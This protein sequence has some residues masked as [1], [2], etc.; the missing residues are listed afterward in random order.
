MMNFQMIVIGLL[1]CL[2]M[3]DVRLDASDG[4]VRVDSPAFILMAVVNIS[5]FAWLAALVTCL[6]VKVATEAG[7]D[8]H[9]Y[10]KL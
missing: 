5:A 7:A 6:Q 4:S 1:V 9:G 10:V 3:S 2:S 8:K